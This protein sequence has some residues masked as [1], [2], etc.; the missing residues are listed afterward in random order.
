EAERAAATA[1]E[2]AGDRRVARNRPERARP[3]REQQ[4]QQRIVLEERLDAAEQHERPAEHDDAEELR[5]PRS[6][7]VDDTADE[8]RVERAEDRD[9]REAPRQLGARPAELVEEWREEHAEAVE[10]AADGEAMREERDGDDPP[11]VVALGEAG[12]AGAAQRASPASR[13]RVS[14]KGRRSCPQNGSSRKR[15]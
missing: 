11:A 12:N 13:S 8:R 15:N 10:D 2:P 6:E 5:R 3:E 7:A 4:R 1:Q 9:R 14:R